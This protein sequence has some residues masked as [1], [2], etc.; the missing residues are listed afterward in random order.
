MSKRTEIIRLTGTSLFVLGAIIAASW[1]VEPLREAWNWIWLLPLA[2][3]I[4]AAI[5]ALG[6]AVVM[7]ALIAERREDHRHESHLTRE[8]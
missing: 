3:R 2:V 4:G 7:I 5:A 1:F 8:P 6:L